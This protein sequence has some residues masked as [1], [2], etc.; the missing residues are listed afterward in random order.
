M[1]ALSVWQ[2]WAWAILHAGKWVENRTWYPSEKII[3]QPIALHASKRQ[4]TPDELNLVR[5]LAGGLCIEPGQC[6][7]GAIVGVVVVTGTVR[8]H[9]RANPTKPAQWLEPGLVA[10][11]LASPVAIAPIPC[12]G[13]QGLWQLAPEIHDAVL[14][15]V[16]L[17]R[18]R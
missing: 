8:P 14:D 6:T 15:A 1:F 12:R 5:R 3:G 11:K 17:K 13:R 18:S 7:L 9:E 16:A 4:P 2:P 10:W